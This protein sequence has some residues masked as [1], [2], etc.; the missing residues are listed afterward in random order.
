[1]FHTAQFAAWPILGRDVAMIDERSALEMGEVVPFG[2]RPIPPRACVLENKTHV[3]TFL[4]EMLDELGFIAREAMTV[5]IRTMLRDF[6]P[7]LIVLGPLDG[8]PE[9]R[10]VMQ[11][12]R[13][14][15]CGAKLMLFGG[16]S[17][18]E[19]IRNFEFG[20]AAGRFAIVTSMQTLPLFS[21]SGRRRLCRSMSTKRSTT[22]GW[23]SGTS[24]K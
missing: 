22:A 21:R 17:S 12:L 23:S 1:M 5:D 2:R 9:V 4:A 8:G 15:S 10:S 18:A 19:L 20:E 11:T 24:Q 6:R 13:A 3:R 14:Q 7:D 16:R